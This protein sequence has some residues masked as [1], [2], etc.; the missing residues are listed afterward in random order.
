[1]PLLDAFLSRFG[2]RRVAPTDTLGAPG[3]AIFG[4]YIEEREKSKD[5]ATPEARYR[6]YADILS[7]TSIVA[8]GIR[9]YANL[10]GGATWTVSPSEADSDAMYAEL[11]EAALMMDGATPWNRVVRRAAMYRF[12]GFSVQ[13]WTMA[14]RMDGWLGYSDIAPRA[15]S[16]I[17]RWSTD[18]TGVVV[19]IVQRSPQTHQEIYLPREKVMYIVDDSLSDSP[20]GLGL[21]RHL[22]SPAKRLARYEDLEGFGFETDLRGIPIGTRAP[23]SELQ[24]LQERGTIQRGSGEVHARPAPQVRREPHPHSEA[25]PP[26]RQRDLSSEDVSGGRPT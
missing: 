16:T 8:A 25:R 2:P 12:Y 24:T 7:N 15:Q 4:G 11:A 23:L 5:L 22:V 19:G 14:R 3:T 13:E 18:E 20:E 9:Y 10:V 6:T 26:A 17:E 1:M 21:F